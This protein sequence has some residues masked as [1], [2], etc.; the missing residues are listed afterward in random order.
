LLVRLETE[1]LSLVRV[2]G[3]QGLLRLKADSSMAQR[4]FR[5]IVDL[6]KAIQTANSV[7]SQENI[8][9]A[10]QL[11]AVERQLEDFL[12]SLPPQTI[13]HGV[14][15]A[16]SPVFCFNE[17]AAFADLWRR[18][19]DDEPELE[20]VLSEQSRQAIRTYLKDAA[21]HLTND[22]DP[23]GE[24]RAHLALAISRVGDPED[25]SDIAALM[26]SDVERIELGLAA[27]ARREH[28]PLAD[29]SLMRYS[30]LY[31][32]AIRHLKSES[33]GSIL[34]QFLQEPNFELQ[35]A[36]ALV[37]WALKTD[38]PSTVWIEGWANRSR[39]FEEI[40][41]ARSAP[42]VKG[43]NEARRLEAIGYLRKHIDGLRQSEGGAS[44]EG[45]VVWRLKD[46]AR[47]LAVLD[48]RSSSG[49]ILEILALPLQAQGTLDG[50]KVLQTLEVLLFVGATLPN[51]KT[52]ALIAPF[53]EQLT[54]KWQSDND[55]T[56]LGVALSVLPF[57]EDIPAGI[58]TLAD[59]LD[60]IN[61]RFDGL[62]RVVAALGHSRCEGAVDVLLSITRVNEAVQRFGQEWL[63]A[64][65]ALDNDRAREI[66]LSVID[67]N[68]PGIQG[69][70][71]VRRDLVL[72]P[73]IAEVAQRHPA[74]KG[75]ILALCNANLDRSR[76]K[77]LG[78]VIVH[79]KDDKSLLASLN[80]LDDDASPEL[81]Y[82]LQNA[83]E[84]AFVERI[85]SRDHSNTYTLQPRTATELREKLIEMTKS[86]P[87]R[88]KSALNLLAQID[89][90]RLEYGRPLGESRNPLVGSG[91]IGLAQ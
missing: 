32:L 90:W 26:A 17:L 87:N 43:F 84:E 33:E 12:R 85:P 88:R 28:T 51:D 13:A 48:G 53:V 68:I 30:N 61:V 35:V 4:I 37:A 70:N 83:I 18:G 11:A 7:R 86:D 47:P 15:A 24:V 79:L 75:R 81:P 40:W 10:Q 29:G 23:R 41:E 44:N 9:L 22:S 56:L 14:V 58:A 49:F 66:L 39:S 62:R 6:R 25:V 91:I 74:M 65:A 1:D 60:R 67:P 27:R 64:I 2:A 69:L 76:K 82:H 55:L 50:W 31:V 45:S 52:V 34:A 63:D 46:L 19:S 71:I 59:Y 89:S 80:L 5:R 54:S 57:V 36:W 42:E 77:L 8:T 72:A 38:L 3:V 16:L 20:E 73:R 21:V 78:E